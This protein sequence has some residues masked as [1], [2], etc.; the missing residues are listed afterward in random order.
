MWSVSS[1]A[2]LRRHFVQCSGDQRDHG[3]RRIRGRAREALECKTIDRPDRAPRPSCGRGRPRTRCPRPSCGRDACTPG[4]HIHT[5]AVMRAGTPAH[6]AHI[7]RLV[8]HAGV[9]PAHPAPT[10][11]MRAGTPAHPARTFTPQPSCG[12]GRPRFRRPQPSCGRDARAPAH[13]RPSQRPE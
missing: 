1:E 7:A 12:R 9:T 10:V 5:A 6:P 4:T 11:V 8:C 13:S 2:T 3:A